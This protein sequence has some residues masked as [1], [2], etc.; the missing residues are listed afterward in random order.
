MHPHPLPYEHWFE[1]TLKRNKEPELAVEI[2]DR[3]RRH[4]YF[5]TLPLG[6]R[7]LSLRWVLEGPKH[8]LNEQAELQRQELLAR[9]PAYQEL[10]V[11]ATK[12]ETELAKHP[13]VADDP[14]ARREQAKQLLS[15]GTISQQQEVLLHEM[16]V[17]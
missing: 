1:A 4:R 17:R 11:Q 5:S 6:G 14:A 2:A 15:L 12:I 3:V 13:L 7:L 8:L 9:F 16:A 10:A